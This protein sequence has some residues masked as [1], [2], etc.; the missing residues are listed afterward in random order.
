MRVFFKMEK[1]A[2]VAEFVLEERDAR[3]LKTQK[4]N[5]ASDLWFGI[6]RGSFSL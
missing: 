6:G 2:T 3:D 4:E 1:R 5:G